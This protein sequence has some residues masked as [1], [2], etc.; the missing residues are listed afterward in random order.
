MFWRTSHIQ[1]LDQKSKRSYRPRQIVVIA[2]SNIPQRDENLPSTF[3]LSQAEDHYRAFLLGKLR[4]EDYLKLWLQGW[5]SQH[6]QILS[7]KGKQT[8]HTHTHTHTHT[9]IQNKTSLETTA[10]APNGKNPRVTSLQKFTK[11]FYRDRLQR[12]NQLDIEKDR[13]NQRMRCQKIRTDCQLV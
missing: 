3:T 8:L 1:T 4:Q 6:S 10:T 5:R 13:M 12:E 7:Q 11:K 2:L 9:N